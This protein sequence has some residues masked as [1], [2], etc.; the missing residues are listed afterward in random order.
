MLHLR[1]IPNWLGLFRILT[2]PLL[3]WLILGDQ[4]ATYIWAVV[5]LLAMA[6]SDMLD[7]RIARHFNVVSPLGV[8][9]DTIS[10]KIF[11]VGTLLPMVQQSLL[12]SWVALLIISRD[13]LISGLRSFAAAEGEVISAGKWG[14]Q[15]L[16]I[17]VVALIWRLLAA[18][19]ERSGLVITGPALHILTFALNLWPIPIALMV[20]WTVFSGGDY[21]YKAWPLLR[22]SWSPRTSAPA[23]DDTPASRP[24]SGETGHESSS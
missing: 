24:Q 21:L 20:I 23:T 10:D 5:L 1:A 8:F 17:T 19:L 9:L 14:K 16:V 6:I 22:G 18:A 15:K 7:G 4:S 11:V 3:V 2:T 13:F 12:S